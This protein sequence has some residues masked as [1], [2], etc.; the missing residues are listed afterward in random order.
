MRKNVRY[1]A[2][3]LVATEIVLGTR[4]AVPRAFN[5]KKNINVTTAVRSKPPTRPFLVRLLTLTWDFL[6]FQ[7]DLLIS[8]FEVRSSKYEMS[9]LSYRINFNFREAL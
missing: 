2:K 4:F 3:K 7:K 6:F 1:A 9:G 5:I 8:E